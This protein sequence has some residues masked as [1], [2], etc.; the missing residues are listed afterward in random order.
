MSQG[1]NGLLL[2]VGSIQVVVVLNIL[3]VFRLGVKIVVVLMAFLFLLE[4]AAEALIKSRVGLVAM[5]VGVA[6]A[7]F[8]QH[9]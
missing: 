1:S 5:A 3:T 8:F 7:R 6:A 9:S 2:G 4:T